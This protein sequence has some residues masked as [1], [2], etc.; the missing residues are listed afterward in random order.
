MPIELNR[1]IQNMRPSPTLAVTAK[2][3]SLKRQ[4]RDILDLGV[5]EPDFPVPGHIQEAG[6]QAIRDG[7]TGYTV[8]DGLPE[9]K[10]AIVQKFAQEN[11]ISYEPDEI[12]VSPGAKAAIYNA[13]AVTLEPG[14]EVVIPAPYWVSYP[15]ITSLCGGV[16]K[17]VACSP[18]RNWKISPDHLRDAVTPQT[19]WLILNSVSNPTGEAYSADELAGLAEVV[20]DFPRLMVLSDD[21][22]EHLVY[23]GFEFATLAG[24]APDLKNRV[25]TVNGVSKAYSMT[26]WRIG[27]AGGPSALITAMRKFMSQTTHNPCTISQWAAITALTGPTDFIRER[28][29]EFAARRDLVVEGLNACPGISCR[30]P[31]GAFYV[32]ADVSALMGRTLLGGGTIQDDVGLAGALLDEAGVAAVPGTAFGHPGAI[33]LSYATDR[34]TLNEALKRI[35]KFCSGLS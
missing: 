11:G 29:T 24:V 7:R 23:G 20:R 34:N 14:D 30:R 19:K 15:D 35:G 12:N 26:G 6:M 33:R 17:I 2:A 32:F 13:F 22:Y 18:E 4:G 10:E 21:I 27:Y 25:L 8:S 9:L 3:Q 31:S 16:P 28:Q 5:G 1:N